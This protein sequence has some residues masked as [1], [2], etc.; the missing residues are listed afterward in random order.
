MVATLEQV[1]HGP[2]QLM[3]HK[4]MEQTLEEILGRQIRRPVTITTL[5]LA[6]LVM[7]LELTELATKSLTHHDSIVL[8][9]HIESFR[10]FHH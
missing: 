2:Q 9:Q 7:E 3:V 10:L 1:R 6:E 4:R 5:A 8:V